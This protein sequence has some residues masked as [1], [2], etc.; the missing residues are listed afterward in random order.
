[1]GFEIQ[2]KKRKKKE[3][4]RILQNKTKINS[5]K[6]FGMYLVGWKQLIVL[7]KQNKP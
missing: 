6:I 1:M 5:N 4:E 7:G 2:E 3:N